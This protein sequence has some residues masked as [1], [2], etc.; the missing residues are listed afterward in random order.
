MRICSRDL[1]RAL[2]TRLVTALFEA[3]WWRQLD[4]SDPVTVARIA[5][6][7][8]AGDG[9]ALVRQAGSPEIKSRLRRQTDDAIARGV[10]GAPMVEVD[11][12]G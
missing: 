7:A 5:N 4:V 12:E 11:D 2:R 8:G 10:F 3:T 1:D 9:A 6:D